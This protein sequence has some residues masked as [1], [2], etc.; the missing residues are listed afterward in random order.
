[1]LRVLQYYLCST[2][3]ARW[4]CKSHL[5]LTATITSHLLGC[6]HFTI[7]FTHWALFWHEIM[8]IIVPWRARRTILVV[9][10]GA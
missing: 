4:A 9:D 10:G 6:P 7:V 8:V 1:M 5:S 3:E 2:K